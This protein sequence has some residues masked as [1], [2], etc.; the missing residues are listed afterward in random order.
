MKAL[1]ITA[2]STLLAAAAIM[3]ASPQRAHAQ[4]RDRDRDRDRGT[5]VVYPVVFTRNSGDDTSRKTA[6]RSIEESLQK[7]GYTIVSGRV[8]AGAW[9]RLG[10]PMPTADD[11][12]R[13]SDLVKLGS[14]LKARYVVSAIVDFHSRS[15]WVD[16]G[17]RTVSSATVDIVITDVDQ[18]KTIYSRQD[19]TGRSDEKFDLAKAG[20]DLLITPLVTIVSGGPKTPHE[21]RAVQIAVAKAMHDWVRPD[22]GYD[23]RDDRRDDRSD[24]R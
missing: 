10:S 23:R 14:T 8:A 13:R 20:A 15:I 22:E 19:V 17:P 6:V 24:N 4:D 16:L 7:A 12:A 3:A 2:V 21:Q 18:D 1:H 9:R 5:A 11:P